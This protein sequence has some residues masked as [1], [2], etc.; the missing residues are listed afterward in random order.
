MLCSVAMVV[1]QG[2]T[3]AIVRL[4]SRTT[5]LKPL[6]AENDTDW[7]FLRQ[8]LL[9]L[10]C[11]L[12]IVHS[13]VVSD[14]LRVTYH[15]S[16]MILSVFIGCPAGSAQRGSCA[17]R[18]ASTRTSATQALTPSA[19][20]SCRS[21]GSWPRTTGRTSISRSA[22]GCFYDRTPYTAHMALWPFGSIVMRPHPSG[23]T[24]CTST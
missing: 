15:E 13:D 16:L 8:S 2:K 5:P 10:W 7:L 22:S 19:G 9:H 12:E 3:G 23:H 24:D 6:T 4:C 18:R 20:P 21:S 11:W 17:L 14:W 1:M